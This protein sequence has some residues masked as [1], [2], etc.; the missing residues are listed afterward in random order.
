[1]ETMLTFIAILK[2]N[3]IISLGYLYVFSF[4][5]SIPI[6]LTI[7]KTLIY[8][9]KINNEC[10]WKNAI[11]L[12]EKNESLISKPLNKKIINWK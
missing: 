11:Y 10:C 2:S 3:F 5:F 12:S 6:L 1:M 7:I 4:F 9:A 8:E